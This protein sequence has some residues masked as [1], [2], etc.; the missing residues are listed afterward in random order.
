[1][2]SRA[3]EL[4]A[5]LDRLGKLGDVVHDRHGAEQLPG[6]PPH[7]TG[8]GD[9]R[10]LLVRRSDPREVLLH[11]FGSEPPFEWLCF[12]RDGGDPIRPVHP[13]AA[14]LLRVEIESDCGGSVRG[15]IVGDELS[16]DREKRHTGVHRIE[17]AA[18]DRFAVLRLF[19]RGLLNGEGLNEPRAA[20]SQFVGR[21]IR[22]DG[23][24]DDENRQRQHVEPLE[25][26]LRHRPRCEVGEHGDEDRAADRGEYD[27]AIEAVGEPEHGEDRQDLDRGYV[28]E[29]C[30]PDKSDADDVCEGQHDEPGSGD[31]M[32]RNEEAHNARCHDHEAA[33]DEERITAHLGYHD[34]PAR[35]HKRRADQQR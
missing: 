17:D 11:N 24:P 4:L 9:H 20:G 12:R 19:E 32:P 29:Q 15:T 27:T 35:D 34:P 18:H 13:V 25:R 14:V 16:V 3:Q 21:E 26:G 1:M 33:G 28:G 23:D 7:E 8:R 30:G 10:G 6:R 31:L 2:R 22:Q 5:N